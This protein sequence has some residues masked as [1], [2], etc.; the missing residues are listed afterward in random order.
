MIKSGKMKVGDAVRYA[1]LAANRA[2]AQLNRK[3][4]S[5]KERKQMR[6]VHKIFRSFVDR[7]KKSGKPKPKKQAKKKAK[8]KNTGRK[9]KK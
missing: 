3:G 5:S 8:K 2:K 9:K 7:F 4:L 6:E 1:N